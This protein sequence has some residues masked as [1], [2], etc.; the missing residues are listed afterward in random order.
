MQE[1]RPRHIRDIAHLYLSRQMPVVRAV[2]L[3]AS[4]GTSF[5]GFHVANIAVAFTRA[6]YAVRLVEQSGLLPD[7]CY[8]L[9]LPSE[10]AFGRARERFEPVAALDGITVFFERPDP[11]TSP[12]TGAGVVDLI[13][14]PPDPAETPEIEGDTVVTVLEVGGRLDVLASGR[15]GAVPGGLGAISRWR[16][17]LR[18]RVPVAVR[19]PESMLSRQYDHL[20][21]GIIS[22]W[23]GNGHAGKRGTRGSARIG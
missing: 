1:H 5:P 10:I 19:D 16:P 12:T 18:D 14:A 21:A 7:S 22:T 20:C 11:P 15:D 8:F 13:H 2:T 6:G 17:A 23:R 9:S 4:S 3:S